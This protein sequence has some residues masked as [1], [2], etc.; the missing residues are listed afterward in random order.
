MA[1]ALK[2]WPVKESPRIQNLNF[3]LVLSQNVQV[4]GPM[5]GVPF[6]PSQHT[7]W[8]HSCPKSISGQ[9]YRAHD[10]GTV[11]RKAGL[12]G[13]IANKCFFGGAE[14]GTCRKGTARIDH[15]LVNTTGTLPVPAKGIHMTSGLGSF[16]F[17]VT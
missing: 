12:M 4:S 15:I 13:L 9:K 17:A 3:F 10:S 1:L 7:Q 16:S 6:P 8:S 2:I 11:D 5:K 14:M